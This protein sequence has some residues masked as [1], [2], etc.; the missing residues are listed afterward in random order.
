MGRFETAVL[1]QPENLAIL[2]SLSG[3]WIG[4]LRKRRPMKELVLD[5][6][7]SVS[8]TYG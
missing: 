1:T 7:S 5:M 3:K 4:R 6:D 2:A 8:E